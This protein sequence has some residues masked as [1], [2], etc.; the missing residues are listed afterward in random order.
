MTQASHC[1]KTVSM[2]V[3]PMWDSWWHWT[4][5]F[6]YYW[7]FPGQNNSTKVPHSSLSQRCCSKTSNVEEW[8]P[9][10]KSFGRRK[11]MVVDTP[12][13]CLSPRKSKPTPTAKL[14]F[15][16]IPSSQHWQTSHKECCGQSSGWHRTSTG[17][18]RSI[19]VFPRQW[20]QHLWC[21]AAHS[22]YSL[23]RTQENN[24][25]I[26]E[27]IHKKYSQLNRSSEQPCGLRR[28]SKSGLL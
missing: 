26:L 9:K 16:W 28:C 23:T 22:Q 13:R 27:K 18:P 5:F 8:R 1:G 25:N 11:A 7:V 6:S 24:K 19:P 2:P 21:S 3:Q 15:Q 4:G 10:K 14:Q 12:W 17:L 20:F